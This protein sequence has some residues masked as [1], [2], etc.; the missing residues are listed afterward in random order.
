METAASAAP[1]HAA[2]GARPIIRRPVG[3]GCSSWPWLAET[4]DVLGEG[5]GREPLDG[6]A[7]EALQV[8][9]GAGVQLSEVGLELSERPS[10][11][12]VEEVGEGRPMAARGRP[13]RRRARGGP[14]G[15]GERGTFRSGLLSSSETV[16]SFKQK[17]GP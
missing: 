7:L 16:K 13:R 6:S 5:V 15:G 4:L 14:G 12:E 17:S 11:G 9:G 8:G 2:L 1:T 3:A 10:V